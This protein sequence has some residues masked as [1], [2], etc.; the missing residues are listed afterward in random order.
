MVEDV[1]Q[2][3]TWL[4]IADARNESGADPAFQ[5]ELVKG[6]YLKSRLDMTEAKRNRIQTWHILRSLSDL[7]ESPQPLD[8]S[9]DANDVSGHKTPDIPKLSERY[10][11]GTLRR[12]A[13]ARRDLEVGHA[14]LNAALS[15]SRWSISSSYA[16][17]GLE[18]VAKIGLA[19]KF[20]RAGESSSI[21]AEQ[22]A[23]VAN[24]ART[25]ELALEELDLRFATA[26]QTIESCN[27]LEL[28]DTATSLEA[29]TMRLSEGK[30]QPSDVIPIRRQFLELRI[31]E[32]H[33]QHSIYAAYAEISTLTAGKL[34]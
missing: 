2:V 6:E 26:I 12:A 17:E 10:Q 23:R 11:M 29:L 28:P 15:D 21:K 16:K 1:S 24:S 5:L 32:L 3:Q 25:A 14:N 19:F 7:P 31:S 34:P 22:R 20:P 33:R 13:I 4:E 9:H 18:R 27:Y 8:Y 30:D